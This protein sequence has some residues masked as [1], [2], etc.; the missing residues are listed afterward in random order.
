MYFNF[1]KIFTF[2]IIISNF[3]YGNSWS[4]ITSILNVT[5]I[6]ID[7]NN[8]YASTNGGLIIID[9]QSQTLS[10]LGLKQGVFPMDLN[11]ILIDSKKNILLGSS[12]PIPS[13]QV[14][15]ENHN[16]K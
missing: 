4:H 7:N 10:S 14:L 12:G 5:D 2:L 13:I 8:I 11:S 9:K 16:K 3:F 6:A 1:L 15:D